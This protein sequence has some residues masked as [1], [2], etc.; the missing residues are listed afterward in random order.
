MTVEY[1]IEPIPGLPGKLP[2]G[3]T[4]IWQGAPDWR[5][6]AKA[7]FHIRLVAGWFLVV[8]ALAFVAGGTG[9]RGALVTLAVALVGLGLLAGLAYAAQ[10]STIYTLTNRRIV[11]RFGAALPKCVNLPLA[12]IGSAD[13]KPAG[14]GF[15]DI[16]LLPTERFPLGWLQ[17]WPHVRPWRASRPQ[18][19]LR[20]VPESFTGILAGA[21][22]KAHEQPLPARLASVESGPQTFPGAVGVAA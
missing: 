11:M 19:M 3:E 12:C 10:R 9:F 2:P 15:V 18:P 6:F 20:A 8:A 1:E 4:I 13:S 5:S 17:M 7:V 21:L 14:D 16:A 22:A